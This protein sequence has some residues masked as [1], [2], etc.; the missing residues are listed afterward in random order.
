M[1]A[2]AT[3]RSV[4]TSARVPGLRA[5]FDTAHVRVYYPAAP[6]G[7]DTERMTGIMPA[8]RGGAPYPV[9]LFLP[10]INVSGD[11]YRWLLAGL[12]RHGFVCAI[13]EVV[14]ETFG[15]GVGLTPVIDLDHL[16]PDT[17]GSGNPAPAL[18]AVLEALAELNDAGPLEGCVDLQR[19]VLGGH[20][21]GGSL[22]LYAC[23]PGLIDG[24]VACFTYAAHAMTST[25]LGWPAG[26]VLPIGVD[27]PAL[28]LG[29]EH[30]GV[31][32]ASAKRYGED[33]GD[34]VDP[35]ARTF[36]TALS[37]GRGDQWYVVLR[38]A[39]H[40]AA[41]HP[42]DE[43]AARSFLDPDPVGDP[44]SIR[45][46]LV[47]CVQTFCDAHVRHDPTARQTLGSWLASPPAGILSAQGK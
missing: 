28:L 44:E 26:T 41:A 7:S 32:A 11:S 47:G 31:I 42:V 29:G 14:G 22:A 2:T 40:F 13:F 45:R 5:P 43:T 30:D 20:S 8:D 1:I 19:V 46:T 16:T 9:V 18:P 3:V 4:Y 35:L 10:G 12:V 17:Y 15:G 37:G 27:I 23:R 38:G 36:D 24:V 33:A 34:R 21:A 6:T 39:N 25:A